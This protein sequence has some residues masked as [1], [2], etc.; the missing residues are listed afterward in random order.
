MGLLRI[1]QGTLYRVWESENNQNEHLQVVVPKSGVS[2]ILNSIDDQVSGKHLG[3][4]K[5]V[6]N[7]ENDYLPGWTIGFD[8]VWLVQQ[9]KS[10]RNGFVANSTSIMW[11]AHSKE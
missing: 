6:A 4:T 9:L 10:H 1:D 3:V 8:Y 5:T 11:G 2:Q 7:F